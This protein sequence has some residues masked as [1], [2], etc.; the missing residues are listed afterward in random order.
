MKD[1]DPALPTSYLQDLDANNLYGLAMVKPLPVSDFVFMKDR[2]IESFNVMSVPEED[3]FGYILEVSLQY[4]HYLH[5][6]HNCFPLAPVSKSV[7][8]E[9]LSPYAQH[10]LR[11]LHRLSE[12]DPLPNRGNVEK[13]STT[14]EDKDH[15]VLHYRNLQL[16][17]NLGMR[18]KNIHRILEFRQKAWMKPY[19]L[20]NTEMRKNARSTFEKNFYKLLN[21]SVFGKVKISISFFCLV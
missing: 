20:H 19:I 6:D 9:E 12:I 4:P 7:S 3:E 1:Y 17:L 18:L 8:N 15:Y 14:L 16:Y 11:K 21:V 10:L 5:D 2:D 13:L